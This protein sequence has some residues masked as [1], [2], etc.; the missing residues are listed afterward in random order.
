MIKQNE[1]T[2]ANIPI[3]FNALSGIITHF[4]DHVSSL[5]SNTFEKK[6]FFIKLK[7][8]ESLNGDN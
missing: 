5:N 8:N 6:I 2:F 4:C 3:Y 7:I 1:W